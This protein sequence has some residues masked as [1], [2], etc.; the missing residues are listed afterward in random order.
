MN[1]CVINGKAYDVNVTAIE[2]S[3]NKL[4]TENT[5][6]TLAN[7]TMFLDPIGTF[8]GHTVEFAPMNN[9]D[10]YY[11]LWDFFKFPHSEGF[12]VELADGKATISYEAYTSSGARKLKCIRNGVPYW[13]GMSI[14]LIPTKAQVLP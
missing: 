6:R 3:F 13:E 8:I 14:N 9:P 12:P 11:E 10:D 4:Y 2:E 1:Y 7:G 5:K